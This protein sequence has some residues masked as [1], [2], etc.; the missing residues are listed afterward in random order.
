MNEYKKFKIFIQECCQY[1]NKNTI[2]RNDLEIIV[3]LLDENYS[4]LC[5]NNNKNGKAYEENQKN[6]SD[7]NKII[8]KILIKYEYKIF[9]YINSISNEND[10]IN[11]FNIKNKLY[12]FFYNQNINRMATIFFTLKNIVI[13]IPVS[14]LIIA[15]IIPTSYYLYLGVF[16]EINSDVYK[17]YIICCLFLISFGLLLYFT[18]II[19]LEYNFENISLYD[20]YSNILK[21]KFLIG[22]YLTAKY[23]LF[24][25]YLF[26][27]IFLALFLILKYNYSL[28]AIAM[29]YFIITVLFTIIFSCNKSKRFY[30]TVI[31]TTLLATIYAVIFVA[32]NKEV[33][34]T[35][36]EIESF[37]N[38]VYIVVFILFCIILIINFTFRYSFYSKF[39]SIL[40][41]YIIKKLN[42]GNYINNFFVDK[43]E[44][45]K[46]NFQ[47][48][49]ECDKNSTGICIDSNITKNF[50]EK[51][52]L[53][54]NVFILKKS[55]VKYIILVPTKEN[56]FKKLPLDKKIAKE[57]I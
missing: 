37:R 40:S 50:K 38:V 10:R 57:A 22:L 31:F 39:I 25:L 36:F 41:P 44:I 46:Y 5:S 3:N 20:K 15:V 23:S 24:I 35:S 55:E 12:R 49:K 52:F 47:Y 32:F 27:F 4:L 7:N 1:Y 18:F 33:I 8:F 13:F 29:I 42:V 9:N 11:K 45:T 54:K 48:I 16:I 6:I 43:T 28:L 17:A 21:N 26:I 14:I 34:S 56:N 51:K 19:P 53:V 2:V 30:L